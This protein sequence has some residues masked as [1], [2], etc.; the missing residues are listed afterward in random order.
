VK[1]IDDTETIIMGVDDLCVVNLWNKGMESFAKVLKSE[2]MG[3]PLH[4]GLGSIC[5][6]EILFRKIYAALDGEEITGHEC[7]IKGPKGDEH[8]MVLSV[9]AR[10]DSTGEIV[11]VACVLQRGGKRS[12]ILADVEA[13]YHFGRALL[14]L[15][16]SNQIDLISCVQIR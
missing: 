12:H 3:R 2:V 11:G 8:N 10:R 13:Q 4:E 15:R 6:D 16:L 7:V 14:Q 1:L 5:F 9:A